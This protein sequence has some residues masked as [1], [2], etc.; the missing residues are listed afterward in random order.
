MVGSGLIRI[1]QTVVSW[2]GGKGKILKKG[3]I[4]EVIILQRSREK[5]VRVKD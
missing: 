4:G 1:A 5:R 3:Q 2:G